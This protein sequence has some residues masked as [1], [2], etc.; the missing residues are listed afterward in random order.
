MHGNGADGALLRKARSHR[1]VTAD[2]DGEGMA[3]KGWGGMSLSCTSLT[4]SIYNFPLYLCRT[5]KAYSIIQADLAYK[6]VPESH[7]G[8]LTATESVLAPAIE[9][10]SQL[11]FW[12]PGAAGR[13]GARRASSK[14][15]S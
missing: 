8:T 15:F 4:L 6:A 5:M 10:C 11:T 9:I 2:E 13:P 12:R 3:A 14:T 1:F 7:S